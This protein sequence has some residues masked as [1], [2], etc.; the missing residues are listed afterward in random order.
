VARCS[1]VRQRGTFILV[2]DTN[3]W[4]SAKIVHSRAVLSEDAV[5]MRWPSGLNAAL[6]TRS[7]WPVSGSPIGLPVAAS[8]SRV[9]ASEDAVTMR[10][11]S[12]GRQRGHTSI[13]RRECGLP[14]TRKAAHCP[15]WRHSD[16]H[17]FNPSPG[18]HDNFRNCPGWG[19][20]QDRRRDF[21]KDVGSPVRASMMAQPCF[22]AVE[23]KERMR[24]KSMAPSTDRK[25]PEIFWRSF[26]MRP[27]RSA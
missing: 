26:I 27:S 6:N 20:V 18:L 24:V 1:R 19:L 12:G 8:H 11:P 15:S 13:R 9:V 23:K 3:A 5:T 2:C 16:G 10:L 22:L 21:A 14:V 25:P 17:G 7:A 4:V